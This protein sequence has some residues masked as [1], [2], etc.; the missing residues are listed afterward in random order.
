MKRYESFELSENEKNL[1][2]PS[3]IINPVMST[4]FKK[5]NNKNDK[6]TSSKTKTKRK[7]LLFFY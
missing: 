1:V 3:I 4:D 2:V 6:K 7:L 5:I